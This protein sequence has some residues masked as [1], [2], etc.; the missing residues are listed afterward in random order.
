MQNKGR[1]Y[2]V[3]T[4]NY[5]VSGS[6][7]GEGPQNAKF[8]GSK[9]DSTKK[10]QY[11]LAREHLGIYSIVSKI[12]KSLHGHYRGFGKGRLKRL[13][14]HTFTIKQ[15]VTAPTRHSAVQ[16]SFHS[17]EAATGKAVHY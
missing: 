17:R 13:S 2:C 4:R 15:S 9:Y 6:I 3:C 16:C 8:K 7:T 1:K 14:L 5:T 12:M 10:Q 11:K